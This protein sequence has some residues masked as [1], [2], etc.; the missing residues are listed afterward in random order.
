[1]RAR[2]SCAIAVGLLIS[3][4]I[5]PDTIL[6]RDNVSVNG[7]VLQVSDGQLKMRARFPTGEREV[8]IPLKDLQ[9]IEFNSVTFNAVTCPL[10]PYR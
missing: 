6:T 5:R 8:W 3:Q 4:A 1:M 7:S 10:S 2:W 9:S